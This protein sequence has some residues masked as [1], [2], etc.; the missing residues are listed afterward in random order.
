MIAEDNA[1]R[2]PTDRVT[3]C[4][5]DLRPDPTSI[6]RVIDS[7]DYAAEVIV[8]AGAQARRERPLG[9]TAGP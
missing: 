2:I 8:N 1:L 6:V 7:F 5:M 4:R 3:E 9:T